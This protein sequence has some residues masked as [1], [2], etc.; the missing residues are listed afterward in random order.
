MTELYIDNKPVA[1]PKDLELTVL[2]QNPFITKNGEFTLDLEI[3]LLERNNIALYGHIERINSS[4]NIKNRKARLYSDNHL[5]LSGQEVVISNTNETVSIQLVAGNSELNYLSNSS[6]LISALDLG[7]I[8]TFTPEQARASWNSAYPANNWVCAPVKA[9]K[10]DGNHIFL[11]NLLGS[12]LHIVESKLELRDRDYWSTAENITPMPYLLFVVEKIVQ[13][14]GY[15]I[16]TNALEAM[17]YRRLFIPTGIQGAMLQDLF[18]D[19]TI[20]T[21][22]SQL[23][24]LFDVAFI[25]EPASREINIEFRK[26]YFSNDSH[27]FETSNVIDNFERVYNAENI[28][29]KGSSGME[30]DFGSAGKDDFYKYE[31]INKTVFDSLQKQEFDTLAALNAYITGADEALK[32]KLPGYL[33]IDKSKGIP[34]IIN[35]ATT[36]SLRRVNT[37]KKVEPAIGTDVVSML[38]MPAQ[39]ESFPCTCKSYASASV[40]YWVSN[41]ILLPVVTDYNGK[42]VETTVIAKDLIKTGLTEHKPD[43]ILPV[44]FWNGA[45]TINI[46]AMG[47]ASGKI[48]F[49][50]ATTHYY[51]PWDNAAY[52]LIDNTMAT[53]AFYSEGMGIAEKLWD[54]TSFAEASTELVIRF[55]SKSFPDVR[56]RFLINNRLF[57]CKQLEYTFDND[58]MSP[59]ITGT[60]LPVII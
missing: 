16:G 18:G 29:V 4:Y 30:Y 17:E 21:F 19:I 14:M 31:D 11:N 13:A 49:C 8:P 54:I 59:I 46:G 55:I 23:E 44:A 7:E 47:G 5:V 12:Q 41:N 42:T 25:L 57:I 52:T 24:L 3:S 33:F 53:M 39:V 60:F 43:N 37:F 2:D 58:G 35:D 28:N 38:I 1:L 56:G 34:Y 48:D 40:F 9:F 15:S 20:G 26:V 45:L 22:I 6:G 32:A 50:Q 27:S 51:A 10:T 36:L